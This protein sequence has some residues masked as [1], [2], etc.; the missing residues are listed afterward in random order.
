VTLDIR[1]MRYVVE[2]ADR[3]NFSR[4][5]ER[6][7]IA[8]PALSQQILKVER[9]LGFDLFDRHPRGAS[10]TSAGAAFVRDA[11]AAVLAF[12]QAVE[13][14]DR[15]ARG[16]TGQ[17]K[18]GFIGGAAQWLTP[19]ILKRFQESYPKVDLRLRETTFM[20]PSGGLGS[21]DSDVAFIRPPIETPGLWFE[22]LIERPRFFAVGVRHALADRAEVSVAEILDEPIIAINGTDRTWE[23]FWALDDFRDGRPARIAG[24]VET[25]EAELQ[26][27]ASG[28]GASV[29]CGATP[30]SFVRPAGIV[31]LPIVDV[32]PSP[33]VVA[34][35]AG[36][37]PALVRNFVQIA[38]DVRDRCRAL[39]HATGRGPLNDEMFTDSL[40]DRLRGGD[41][42][43][44]TL[45]PGPLRV[46]ARR[47]ES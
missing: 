26:L 14:A 7:G 28:R 44:P 12:D 41:L 22:V 3:G 46:P 20:D 25:F 17:L 38:T 27:V 23:R 33:V 9:E 36:E 43:L 37:A 1:Q 39:V 34:Y 42:N 13:R 6:L 10:V 35:R 24:R 4:A 30:T 31:F 11:Q 18:L 21:G 29:T 40:S 32:P 8:Q 15:R 45:P 16:E 2:V 19:F 47:F 5:A